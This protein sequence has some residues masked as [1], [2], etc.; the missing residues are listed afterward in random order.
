MNEPIEIELS[1]KGDNLY[2][3]FGGI[4]AS[5]GMP[6]FEF[7]NSSKIID[8]HKIF[9]RDFSQSWYQNGLPSVSHDIRSTARYL[10]AQIEVINPEKIYFVGNS[11]GGYA[12]ILFSNLIDLG[13]VIAFAPQT[14]ISPH[15]RMKHKDGR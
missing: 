3:F 2:L 7:Y 11:M 12:A 1:K 5:I 10:K 4:L 13:E 6:P 8:Q 15:L 9:V 14:F